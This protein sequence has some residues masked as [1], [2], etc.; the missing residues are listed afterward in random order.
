LV[1][2][3]VLSA[4]P[5]TVSLTLS[6]GRV[7]LTYP[8]SSVLDL[9]LGA[10]EIEVRRDAAYYFAAADWTK[11]GVELK[12]ESDQGAGVQDRISVD[13]QGRLVMKRTIELP[14]GGSVEGTLVYRRK[15]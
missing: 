2:L 4:T 3:Q 1:T 5:E 15:P 10:D 14:M 13:E 12:R 7:V 6:P 11:K 8:D 9:V